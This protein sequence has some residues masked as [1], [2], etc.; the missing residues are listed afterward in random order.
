[1]KAALLLVCLLS[2]VSSQELVSQIVHILQGLWESYVHACVDSLKKFMWQE[3]H[4]R[5]QQC[6][7]LS[8]IY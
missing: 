8:L 4:I 6:S 1:M 7:V 3:P 2:V 5:T